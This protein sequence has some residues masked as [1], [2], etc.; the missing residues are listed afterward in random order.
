MVFD[1]CTA[2]FLELLCRMDWV[3]SRSRVAVYD[4]VVAVEFDARWKR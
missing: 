1:T 3:I 2:E 4:L